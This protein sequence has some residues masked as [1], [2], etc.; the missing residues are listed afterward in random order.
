MPIIR[1][2][3]GL[4][5]GGITMTDNERPSETLAADQLDADL[6]AL[7]GRF[8][9]HERDDILMELKNIV[10]TRLRARARA[11]AGR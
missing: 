2:A 7:E 8:R 6:R 10:A 1:G 9:G 3:G 5:A 11:A 4:H